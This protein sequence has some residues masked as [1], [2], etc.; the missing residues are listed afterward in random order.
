MQ[1][2]TAS[3]KTIGGQNQLQTLAILAA[4]AVLSTT[5]QLKFKA[6]LTGL[7]A[8]ITAV[9]PTLTA[10]KKTKSGARILRVAVAAVPPKPTTAVTTI[11]LSTLLGTTL[12]LT[13][14]QSAPTAAMFILKAIVMLTAV[15]M[16]ASQ[17]IPATQTHIPSMI[18]RKRIATTAAI[19]GLTIEVIIT[20]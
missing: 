3:A 7:I 9:P 5:V 11:Q 17:K 6:K 1:S 14:K 2:I 10:G 19:I 18:L 16:T 4:P 15:T 20:R 13:A 8:A 12:Q